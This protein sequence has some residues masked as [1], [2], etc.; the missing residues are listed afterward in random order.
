MFSSFQNPAQ[1]GSAVAHRV[2]R[3]GRFSALPLVVLLA[4]GTASCGSDGDDVETNE[5]RSASSAVSSGAT[6][7]A[8]NDSPANTAA[9]DATT[10]TATT[11]VDGAA[12]FGEVIEYEARTTFMLKDPKVSTD[13][14]RRWLDVHLTV[15]AY[16]P[17]T[18]FDIAIVCYPSA[19]LG[20]Y[21]I[22]VPTP[23]PAFPITPVP[24]GY[25]IDIP[26]NTTIEGY[27]S[28]G[29]PLA[30]NGSPVEQCAE[31]PMRIVGRTNLGTDHIIFSED[32]AQELLAAPS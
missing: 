27:V 1:F 26:G 4:C 7:D 14:A 12:E 5:T 24:N 16:F 21:L 30:D 6:A 8:T 31:Q 22:D 9:A 11:A 20:Q 25:S 19:A 13:G 23:S 18:G 32:L 28:L 3:A 15:N 29:L 2:P 17:I 10:D